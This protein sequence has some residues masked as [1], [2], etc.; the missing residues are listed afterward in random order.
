MKKGFMFAAALT[1][2]VFS[3]AVTAQDKA[4]DFGGSWTLDVSKSKLGERNNIESQTLTV[5]QTDKDIK[6]ATSTKRMAP[7][8]GGGGGGM[9]GGGRPGGGGGMGGGGGR[10]GGGDNT[11]TYTLDGKES[12]IMVETQ[13]GQMPLVLKAKAKDGKLKLSQ[14]RTMTTQMG[15]ITINTDETW[16]LGAD[17]KSLTVKREQ[18]TPQG[19]NST[20]LVYTKN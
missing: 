3:L 20:T 15:E 9:G 18:T 1:L 2:F 7:P 17:G 8:A 14:S 10:A 16:E 6:V 19:T 12:K 5:T 4:A 13:A 11:S